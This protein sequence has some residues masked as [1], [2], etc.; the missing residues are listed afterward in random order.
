MARRLLTAR[1]GGIAGSARC[2]LDRELQVVA[3][4]T[5]RRHLC[6]L[7]SHN[8]RDGAALVLD[9]SSGQVL[10]YVGNGGEVSS[11]RHVGGTRAARQAGSTLKPFLYGL[12]FE[13]RALTPASLIDDRPLD[14]PVAGGLYQPGNYDHRYRGPVSC[15]TA[16]ASSL[17]VPA[18]RVL[19]L[20]GVESLVDGLEALGFRSLRAADYYGPS[21]AMGSADITLWDLAAAY[22]ALARGGTTVAPTLGASGA[23]TNGVSV[24]SPEKAGA[25]RPAAARS[26]PGRPPSGRV[27][28]WKKT[29]CRASGMSG[30][31]IDGA[32]S[33]G[34]T[35]SA[36]R[37]SF[38]QPNRGGRYV[39][40]K[41]HRNQLPVFKEF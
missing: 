38:C 35:R 12:A 18:V 11:A 19:E 23:G 10:A 37:L 6:L 9:H 22:A 24:L 36:S 31:Q 21:L 41:G 13:G 15:P 33:E 25:G 14:L 20:V 1:D 5:V 34:H 2:S 27:E 8:L 32:T 7:G 4:E 3:T 17:N 40:R 29:R 16:L 28:T 39:D 26:T 30:A